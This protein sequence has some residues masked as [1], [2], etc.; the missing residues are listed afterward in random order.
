MIA[1]ISTSQVASP[2][3]RQLVS[4]I[5]EPGKNNVCM[6]CWMCVR[7]AF[8]CPTQTIPIN[9][10]RGEIPTNNSFQCESLFGESLNLNKIEIIMSPKLPSRLISAGEWRPCVAGVVD[11]IY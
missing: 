9:L 1:V 4:L 7:D 6:E 3:G 2:D 8:G 10:N 5:E 11:R